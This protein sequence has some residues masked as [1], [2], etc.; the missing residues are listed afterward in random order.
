MRVF[1][2]QVGI[3]HKTHVTKLVAT[4]AALLRTGW[5]VI[6]LNRVLVLFAYFGHVAN[7]AH[8]ILIDCELLRVDQSYWNMNQLHSRWC[9]RWKH[10]EEIVEI[11]GDRGFEQWEDSFTYCIDADNLRRDGGRVSPRAGS[12]FVVLWPIS[13]CSRDVEGSFGQGENGTG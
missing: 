9:A 13:R 7:K 2:C 6:Q 1:H 8:E 3:R 5:N 10:V 4:P 11:G 12:A